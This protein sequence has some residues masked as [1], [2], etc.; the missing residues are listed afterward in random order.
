MKKIFPLIA[1]LLVIC[2]GMALAIRFAGGNGGRKEAHTQRPGEF[3]N[4]QPYL[5][6]KTTDF[7]VNYPNWPNIDRGQTAKT[8]NI[9]VAVANAGCNFII[10][11]SAVAPNT[12][13]EASAEKVINAAGNSLK[14]NKK[15]IKGNKGY[16]DGDV[17]MGG[18]TLKN[19]SLEFKTGNNIYG[20]AFVAEKNSF[21]RAC[22]PLV[23][24]VD[25]SVKV[26]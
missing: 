3:A 26:N 19:V 8:D 9:Q 22:E 20:M 11:V 2:A 12:T 14:I 7:E 17:T 4:G 23:N 5:T 24:E 13:L 16:L 6:F 21:S 1:V 18:V 25:K 10:K 15:E